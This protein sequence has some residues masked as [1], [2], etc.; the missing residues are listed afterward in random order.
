MKN[1]DEKYYYEAFIS[2]C[3]EKLDMKVAEILHR[4]LERYH[5][6]K[7]IRQQINK[8]KIQRVFRD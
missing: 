2:Y 6:P 1:N 4:K 7:E 8:K 5:I 3:Y